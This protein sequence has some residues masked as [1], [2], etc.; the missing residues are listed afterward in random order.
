MSI[1]PSLLGQSV[2]WPH[3]VYVCSICT[4]GF[5]AAYYD[6]SAT[7]M[8]DDKFKQCGCIEFCVKLIKSATE[9]LGILLQT[10]GKIFF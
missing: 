7:V 3:S 9:A 5:V 4:H 1:L 2:T 8:M 6:C 10:F